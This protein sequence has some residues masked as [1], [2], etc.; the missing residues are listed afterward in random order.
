M[1][2]FPFLQNLCQWSLPV[3]PA[4]VLQ[5]KIWRS[6]SPRSLLN[7]WSTCGTFWPL[8]SPY[9]VWWL[10]HTVWP[11]PAFLNII[12]LVPCVL[13][14][15]LLT[16]AFSRSLALLFCQTKIRMFFHF[17]ESF[18]CWFCLFSKLCSRFRNHPVL[19]FAKDLHWPWCDAWC[20]LPTLWIPEV[21]DASR[22]SDPGCV[23]DFRNS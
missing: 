11:W 2:F 20:D 7:R 1:C 18:C 12:G 6:F 16:F 3:N 21:F 5:G 22:A 14:F 15:P 4:S 13:E 10:C 19:Q 8:S 9:N 23:K 17:F